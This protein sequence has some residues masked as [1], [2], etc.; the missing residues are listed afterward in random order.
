MFDMFYLSFRFFAV[1]SEDMTARVF[2][3]TPM[4]GHH[5]FVVSGHRNIIIGCFFEAN[6]L[7]VSFHQIVHLSEL[8][9]DLQHTSHTQVCFVLH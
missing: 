3:I 1:G 7:N 8:S 5:A 2:S 9:G 4:G 6:S